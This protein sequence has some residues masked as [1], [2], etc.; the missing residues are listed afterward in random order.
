[1]SRTVSVP[2]EEAR[3]GGPD[4]PG[5]V[6]LADRLPSQVREELPQVT[7]AWPHTGRPGPIS[8]RFLSLA[9]AD[10]S[11]SPVAHH[12]GALPGP[13]SEPRSPREPGNSAG[14]ACAS[15]QESAQTRGIV[16]DAVRGGPDVQRAACRVASAA[17]V[18]PHPAE[19]RRDR[20][21]PSNAQA[22]RKFG[23]ASGS[24][25]GRTSAWK[26]LEV[27]ERLQRSVGTSRE[28][29]PHMDLLPSLYCG[30]SGR[31][32]RGGGATRARPVAHRTTRAIGKR[33]GVLQPG[34]PDRLRQDRSRAQ[35]MAGRDPR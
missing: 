25:P 12:D 26:C 21:V 22:I 10:P 3:D 27:A 6:G 1:M 8:T 11:G 29:R 31:K 32:Y 14:A 19:A 4:E 17:P 34:A 18:S 15:G 20:E 2:L 5:V 30:R 16:D 7:A 13:T 35:A 9:E 23:T 28:V 24:I 33:R